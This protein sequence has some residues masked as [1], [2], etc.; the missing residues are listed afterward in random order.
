MIQ[1]L[2][3]RV[4]RDACRQLVA[5]HRGGMMLRVSVNLSVQQLQHD[6][7]CDE[8]V[9]VQFETVEHPAEP[10]GD[11]GLPLLRRQVAEARGFRGNQSS[12]KA[13]L[14][15]SLV[16]A[17]AERITEKADDFLAR[18]NDVNRIA[19]KSMLARVL[20]ISPADAAVLLRE[21]HAGLKAIVA[22]GQANDWAVEEYAEAVRGA[23]LL[24][25]DAEQLEAA[26]VDSAPPP[27][28]AVAKA[29]ADLGEMLVARPADPPTPPLAPEVRLRKFLPERDKD[30]RIV[31]I[32]ESF[33]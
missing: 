22:E 31:A 29:V 2:G 33:V 23:R 18:P 7:P 8:R 19:S 20:D 3:A 27:V 16:A 4:L 14:N 25:L 5:W 10:H 6:R 30:G 24:S 28:E 9:E 15:P 26:P 11:A 13:D 1:A 32:V 17:I 12:T 21:V